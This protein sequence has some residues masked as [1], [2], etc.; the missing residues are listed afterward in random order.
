MTLIDWSLVVL[1]L[2]SLLLGVLRGFVREVIS[3]VGWVAGTWLAIRYAAPLGER[4]PLEIEWPIVK[5]VLA[6]MA[7]IA[8]CVFAAALIGWIARRLLVAA[9]LSAAD[10]ALG[11][12]FGL[13]RGALIVAVAVYFAR[14]TAL[15]RQ[16]FW[17]DSFVLPQVEAAVRFASR[18]LPVAG[19]TRG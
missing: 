8:A 17:R 14:D 13:A 12:V 9:Q 1:V 4:I 11:G 18:H 5:T 16:P 2:V 15:A 19:P 3:I 10:R 7:I 6:G